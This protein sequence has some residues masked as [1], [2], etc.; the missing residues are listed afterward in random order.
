MKMNQIHF[1][2]NRDC[3]L[4]V[5]KNALGVLERIEKNGFVYMSTY[6]ENLLFGRFFGRT[7]R[8]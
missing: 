8:C 7:N 5:R 3:R 1:R 6:S 4:F 2:K